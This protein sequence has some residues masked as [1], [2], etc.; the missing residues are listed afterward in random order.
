MHEITYSITTL[1]RHLRNARDL[2]TFM[3]VFYLISKKMYKFIL[4]V[5]F[6]CE[7]SSLQYS[8]ILCNS[9][10]LFFLVNNI[11]SC[12]KK[13]AAGSCTCK[14]FGHILAYICTFLAKSAKYLIARA[15]GRKISCIQLH[16]NFMQRFSQILARSSLVLLYG[17]H[18]SIYHTMLIS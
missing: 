13:I 9:K 18:N 12:Y 2:A 1:A 14:R 5:E 8:C 4:P 15:C 3:Q 7:K 11:Y 10:I 6:P 17:M 16:I